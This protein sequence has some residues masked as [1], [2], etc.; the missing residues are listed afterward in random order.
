MN[1]ILIIV[2][3]IVSILGLTLSIKTII[4]TRKKYYQEYLERK[5]MKKI[6]SFIYLDN[7]KMYSISSQI[8]E[9]LTEY[10]L[11]SENTNTKEKEEQKGPFFSGRVL[12][13][14]IEK[15]TNYTEKNFFMI[16]HIIYLRK[17]CKRMTEF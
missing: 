15:D 12:A 3:S 16:F 11:K 6:R 7:Y 9:G 17:H 2:T 10:I 8:F 1:T 4:D 13:D 14:I 5:K